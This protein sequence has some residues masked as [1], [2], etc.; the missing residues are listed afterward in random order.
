LAGQK[1]IS[2]SSI[3][4]DQSIASLGAT[5]FHFVSMPPANVVWEQ[6]LGCREEVEA[7]VVALPQAVFR[8]LAAMVHQDN[9]PKITIITA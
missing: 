9:L 7:E 5:L 1:K 6:E 3:M 4:T 2:I 8:P